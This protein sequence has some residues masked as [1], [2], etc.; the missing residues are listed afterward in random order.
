[1]KINLSKSDIPGMPYD[2]ILSFIHIEAQNKACEMGEVWAIWPSIL[3]RISSQNAGT[4]SLKLKERD[5]TKPR[6]AVET[7]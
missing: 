6:V 3:F 5:L 7:P 4:L 1:L 2:N